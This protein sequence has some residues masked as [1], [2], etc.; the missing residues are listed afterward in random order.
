MNPKIRSKP[1]TA[2]VALVV[3]I[4]IMAVSL[5]TSAAAAP[6][7]EPSDGSTVGYSQTGSAS[8]NDGGPSSKMLP[9][10][11][12]TAETYDE[13]ALR[14]GLALLGLSVLALGY[15]I[16]AIRGQ[17]RGEKARRARYHSRWPRPTRSSETAARP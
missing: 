11:A 12:G 13:S 6:V 14:I 2:M 10:D 5:G 16:A 1:H 3:S 15:G 9:G 17:P 4:A 8:A 7:S